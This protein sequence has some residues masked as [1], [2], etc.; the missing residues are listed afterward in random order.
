MCGASW[1]LVAIG[2]LVAVSRPAK[3]CTDPYLLK[4]VPIREIDLVDAIVYL[5]GLSL[6]R[7]GKPK[8][9]IRGAVVGEV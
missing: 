9:Q 6:S 3:R 7:V 4:A 8:Y 2:R 1:L 5:S